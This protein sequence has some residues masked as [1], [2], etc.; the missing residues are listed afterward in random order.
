MNKVLRD[1]QTLCA[2][3]GIVI[4]SY[5]QKRH[6]K[7][8]LQKENVQFTVTAAVSAGD[9]Y[10][11]MQNLRTDMRRAFRAAQERGTL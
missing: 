7:L 10:R 6:F 4:L 9:T 1:L 5:E 3:E 11:A 2:Q 8:K